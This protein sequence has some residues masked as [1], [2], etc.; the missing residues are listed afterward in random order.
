MLGRLAPVS[1]D[2][3]RP[4][5]TTPGWVKSLRK[6]VAA[7]D[8]ASPGE[9]G[10]YVKELGT[11]QEF[12]HRGEEDWYLAS[13]VKVPIAV[14]V[15]RQIEA[16]RFTLDT[17][18]KLSEADYIDGAGETNRQVSGSLLSVR[19]LLEQMLIHSD[20]TASDLLIRL[21]GLPQINH[22]VQTLAPAGFT[23]ITTLA[24]VRRYAYGAF[25]T[26]ASRLTNADIIHLKAAPNERL[27]MKM[28]ANLLR[29]SE[30]D[31]KSRSL[32]AAFSAYYAERLN[33]A[34]LRAYGLLLEKIA[35]GELLQAPN[36]QYLLHL[37]ERAETGKK[38][39]RAGLPA[40]YIFAHKTGTQYAR[41][42]DFGIVRPK[43]GTKRVVIAACIRGEP[44]LPSA[45]LA[46]KDIGKAVAAS[47]VLE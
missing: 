15:L 43:N 29:V 42:C 28:L 39:I 45:E 17:P 34:P 8:A 10:L 5:T 4:A 21:T 47:G 14:E 19:F 22:A 32:D 12:S 35:A 38:R 3:N 27:R 31:F 11:G 23:P 6:R 7:L 13:G 24:D 37:M 40:S 18:V 1:A 30:N 2:S 16:G 36:T 20:N 46:L 9:L 26:N 33:T 41:F 44:S 25:H